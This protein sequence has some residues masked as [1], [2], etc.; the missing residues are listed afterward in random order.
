MMM[1][2]SAVDEKD[3]AHTGFM[4]Q[5][6]CFLLDGFVMAND[7]AKL[8]ECRNDPAKLHGRDR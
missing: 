3:G 7:F 4:K 2:T 8:L 5:V 1:G 6:L